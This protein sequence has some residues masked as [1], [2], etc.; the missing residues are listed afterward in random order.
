[1]HRSY[2]SVSV[3]CQGGVESLA[4]LRD[5]TLTDLTRL[6]LARSVGELAWGRDPT[7]VYWTL[8]TGHWT[9]DTGHWTLDTGHWTL[10]T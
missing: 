6:G 2:N 7:Q 5:C 1:M 8:D 4:Q 10:D 9:L 3:H